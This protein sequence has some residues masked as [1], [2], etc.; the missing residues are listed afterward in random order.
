MRSSS[1]AAIHPLRLPSNGARPRRAAVEP[2]ADDRE[3]LA[4]VVDYYH[5]TLKESPEALAIS[6]AAASVGRADRSLPA[7]LREP[8]AGL[9]ASPKKK[10]AGAELRGRL[11]KLGL[12]RESGHEHFNGSLVVPIFDEHG[13]VV[14]MYGRKI[15]PLA[16]EEGN[17]AASLPAGPAPRCLEPGSAASQQDRILCEALIDALTFWCAGFRN[18]TAS[19]GVD[20][21]TADHLEAFK[22]HGTETVLI[23]YDRDEAGDEA[24][25]SLAE[26]LMAWGSSATA[27]SS[28][29]AWM[30]TS[31]P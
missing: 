24:A 19:Y 9:P 15:T 18:V 8:H 26:K 13:E 27:S 25:A 23:A 17:A 14:G 31:T 4:R 10:K 22:R 3:L 30:R 21:F 16:P 28:R 2:D 5:E 6:K 1:C 20:G 11:Q 12:L 7:R 29:R